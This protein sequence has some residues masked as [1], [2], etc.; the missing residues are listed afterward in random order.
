MYRPSICLDGNLN[1]K[2][3]MDTKAETQKGFPLCPLCPLY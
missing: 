1:T 2:D 3:T